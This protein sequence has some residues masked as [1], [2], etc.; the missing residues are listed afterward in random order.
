[1]LEHTLNLPH[2]DKQQWLRSVQVARNQHQRAEARAIT[3]Q[4]AL[5]RNWLQPQQPIIP[6][7]PPAP[8]Y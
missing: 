4:R 6:L 1:M 2:N 8:N 5:L 7:P 3:T